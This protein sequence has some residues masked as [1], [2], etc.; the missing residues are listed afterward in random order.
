MLKFNTI[1]QQCCSSETMYEGQGWQIIPY[2]SAHE[3]KGADVY[4]VKA[5]QAHL[6]RDELQHI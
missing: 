6:V 5:I 4:L 2:R 3:S 1:V